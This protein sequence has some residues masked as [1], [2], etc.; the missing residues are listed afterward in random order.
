MSVAGSTTS[1]AAT[2]A[3]N[4][5]A[6]IETIAI[7]RDGFMGASHVRFLQHGADTQVGW[8]RQRHWGAAGATRRQTSHSQPLLFGNQVGWTRR[9]PDTPI[10]P[11]CSGGG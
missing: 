8:T 6:M 1:L 3:G 5:N 2:I 11:A 4:A 10:L 9:Y 7:S